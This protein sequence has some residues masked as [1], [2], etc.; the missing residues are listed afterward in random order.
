MGI[1]ISSKN[2]S[3]DMSSAGFIRLRKTIA[4]LYSDEVGKHYEDLMSCNTTEDYNNYDL[5]TVRLANNAGSKFYWLF[6]FLYDSDIEGKLT[7]G[8]CRKLL[9]LIGDYDDNISYGYVARPDCAKFKD[10]KNI[11]EDCVLNKCQMEWY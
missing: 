10:F 6:D 7:Y 11:L 2:K 4:Y 1:T 5:E 3:I 9:N 8:K